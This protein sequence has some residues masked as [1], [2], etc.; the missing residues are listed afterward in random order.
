M[1]QVNRATGDVLTVLYRDWNTPVE[2]QPPAG[3]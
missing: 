3:D 2:I 1:R